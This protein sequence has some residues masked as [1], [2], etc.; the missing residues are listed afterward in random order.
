MLFVWGWKTPA[1]NAFHILLHAFLCCQLHNHCIQTNLLRLHGF[2][3]DE[4]GEHHD[5]DHHDE[6]EGHGHFKMDFTTL[7]SQKRQKNNRMFY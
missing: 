4:D 1:H 7:Q 6:H 5:D 3:N 2:D